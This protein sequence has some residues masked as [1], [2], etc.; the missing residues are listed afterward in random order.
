MT[1]GYN[2]TVGIIGLGML[3]ASIAERLLDQGIKTN[4]YNR[5]KTK[6]K[7]FENTGA[8]SFENICSLANESD[9]IITCVTNFESLKDVFFNRHGII[10]SNNNQ[11][12]IADCTTIRPD[13]SSYCSKLL[14][15]KKDITLLSAPVMGGPS[16]AKNG[17]LIA[18]ISGDKKSFKS[19]H[20]IFEKISKHIFYLGEN[21]GTSNSVKLALNLNIAIIS[22]ALSE[23]II[24]AMHSGI[25]PEVYLKILN[26]TKLKTSISEN[27]GQKILKNDFT[28]SFFLKN[29]L[30]DL[31]LVMEISQSLQISLP[32]TKLSQQLFQS[33]NNCTNL[34]NKDYSAIFQFLNELNDSKNLNENI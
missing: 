11:L 33:A 29:M 9:F 22:L 16:D 30:K 21:N 15:E 8:K 5:D 13:Q 14:R 32:I 20:N 3:G 10:D 31:D 6:L 28:P 23:G 4:I 7:V 18:M 34:K 12:I 2:K 24:L 25:D 26:L 27:K 19:M 1:I 17:E